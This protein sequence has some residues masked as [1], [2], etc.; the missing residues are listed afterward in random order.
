MKALTT[1]LAML[2]AMFVVGFVV[3]RLTQPTEIDQ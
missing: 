3:G 1:L 2:L